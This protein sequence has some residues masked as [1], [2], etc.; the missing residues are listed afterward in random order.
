MSENKKL[1]SSLKT[2]TVSA[3]AGTALALTPVVAF[4]GDGH[5]HSCSGK[6]AEKSCSGEKA[7]KSCSG[8]KGCSG[9]KEEGDK[10]EGES[11]CSGEK[12]C[13]GDKE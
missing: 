5:D 9:E 6:K 11:S 8:E 10:E 13:S 3:V 2:L 1:F 12:G 7:E 4:A